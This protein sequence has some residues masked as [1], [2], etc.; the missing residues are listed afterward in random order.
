MVRNR[1][2]FLDS[3]WQSKYWLTFTGEGEALMGRGCAD[4]ITAILLDQDLKFVLHTKR[5]DYEMHCVVHTDIVH[6]SSSGRLIN[7]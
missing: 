4:G 7:I 2:H 6:A 5:S 1:P 3:I